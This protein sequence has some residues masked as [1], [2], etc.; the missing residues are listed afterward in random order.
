MNCI[1]IF[2]GIRIIFKVFKFLIINVCYVLNKVDEL[3]GVVEM[4]NVIVV[5]VIE[6]CLMDSV[7]LIVI[8]IGQFFNVFC[9]DRFILGGGVLVYVYS[10][11]LIICL[12]NIEVSDKEVLWL[13][14]ML[15]WILRFFSCII[16]VVLYFLLGK[17][18][19]GERELIDYIIECLDNLLIERFLV[20]II[21]IGDF[22]YFNLG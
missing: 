19:I 11:I 13:F 2:I 1:N 9:K 18:C 12:E 4:N 16:M 17:M 22:N 7:L 8:S 20:G 5:I 10:F 14:Y 21:I 15:F 3:Y 6:F